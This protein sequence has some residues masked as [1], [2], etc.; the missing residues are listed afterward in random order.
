M[1]R[2]YG[3]LG[4]LRLHQMTRG[5][6]RAASE[7]LGFADH[8][9]V[10][11]KWRALGLSCLGNEV[12][13]RGRNLEYQQWPERPAE[14]WSR[15][16]REHSLHR[17]QALEYAWDLPEKVRAGFLIPICDLHAGHIACDWDRF[18]VLR[19]WLKK[20]PQARWF[21]GGDNCDVHTTGSPG[22]SREQFMPLE[23][24]IDMVT[25]ELLPVVEQGICVFD[26]NHEARVER[27]TDVHLTA[28]QVLA[29]DLGLPYLGLHGHIVHRV[30]EQT[31]HHF[32]HHGK[33]FA[34]T[35]GGKLNMALAVA[36]TV[37]DELVTVGHAHFEVGAK[38]ERME[39]GEDFTVSPKGQHVELC[40]SFFSY[41]G[42]P[43]DKALRPSSLG[44]KTLHL[45][46][47]EHQI[48]LVS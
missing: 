1:E 11:V 29:K 15:L 35:E 16:Y 14:D 26:G 10:S 17:E 19:D 48:R 38:R 39:V 21:L 22:S 18:L 36:D 8:K 23:A 4:L 12:P 30:G 43:A 45:S 46:T 7:F 2:A 34:N 32:H 31:Y 44:V 40:P 33:G 5:N 42:Y 47:H 28:G 41:R 25:L 13:R 37:T 9:P 6:A 24:A 20:H 3:D 27:E